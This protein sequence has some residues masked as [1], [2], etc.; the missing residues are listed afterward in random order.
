MFWGLHIHHE[1]VSWYVRNPFFWNYPLGFPGA[2]SCNPRFCMQS[3]SAKAPSQEAR[4]A[5]A[6]ILGSLFHGLTYNSQA[7]R[8]AWGLS[9][10]VRIPSKPWNKPSYSQYQACVLSRRD[11][12]TLLGQLLLRSATAKAQDKDAPESRISHACIFGCFSK[13]T[14]KQ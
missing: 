7:T 11:S 14:P 2:D 6:S 1:D 9:K 5:W 3:N 12:A 10:Y 4:G 8:R 13:W